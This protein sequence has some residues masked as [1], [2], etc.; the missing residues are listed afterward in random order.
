MINETN[1]LF[2]IFQDEFKM[3]VNQAC[4]STLVANINQ[5]H[6]LSRLNILWK[7]KKRKASTVLLQF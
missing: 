4:G 5:K 1:L 3:Q 6:V 7:K 2:I